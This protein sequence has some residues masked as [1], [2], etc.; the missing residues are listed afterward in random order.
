MANTFPKWVN[1]H[2]IFG[3]I[4]AKTYLV[5]GRFYVV[6]SRYGVNWLSTTLAIWINLSYYFLILSAI[7]WV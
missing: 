4:A 6:T 3:G 7:L 2:S 1:S 5:I